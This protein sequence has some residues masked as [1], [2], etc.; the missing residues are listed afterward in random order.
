MAKNPKRPLA[1]FLLS[2]YRRIGSFI[3]R[4]RTIVLN[5]TNNAAIFVTPSPAL[6]DVTKNIDDLEKAEAIAGTRVAG[7][8]ATRDLAYATVLEDTHGL[9]AYVQTL[10]D[11]S[12]DEETAISIIESSG[13]DLRNH[14]VRVKAPLSATPGTESQTI[15]LVAKA[16]DKRASY[17]WQHS[18]DGIVWHDLPVTLQAKTI[19]GGF[20]PTQKVF[21]RVRGII[22]DATLPWTPMVSVIIQ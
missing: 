7:S 11:N 13:F 18:A 5:I 12:P 6:V 17:Q 4:M 8:V 10:A 1:V 22:K 20:T 16:V 9:Q 3:L 15:N 2:K 14:G 19:A 21:F